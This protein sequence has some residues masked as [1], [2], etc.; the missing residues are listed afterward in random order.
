MRDLAPGRLQ[1]VQEFVNSA[2]LE[3]G[4]DDVATPAAMRDWLRERGLPGAGT[5]LDGKAHARL[6]ALREA[7]REALAANCDG[8][9]ASAALAALDRLAAR[10]PLL[11]RFAA[12]GA[13]L[14]PAAGGADA[15]VA[16]LLGIVYAAM[17]E[18]SWSRLKVCRR[19]T[20]R[21]AF[22]DAS[23]NRSG[24]WCSMQGCGNREKV[25]AYQQRRR[26]AAP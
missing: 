21:W 12:G 13:E 10:A 25:R 2:D 16:G 1:L 8:S 5:P 7:L 17:V 9:P 18:G 23:K 19:R 24:A 26:A 14:R 11:V 6:L 22:Y 20:C 15:A 3:E 4:R